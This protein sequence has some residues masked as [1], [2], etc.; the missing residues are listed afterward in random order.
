MLKTTKVV[1][2][3]SLWK[4]FLLILWLVVGWNFQFKWICLSEAVRLLK[5]GRNQPIR[6]QTYGH[7]TLLI[8]NSYLS[9]CCSFCVC[10]SAE[11]LL[12]CFNGLQK[13][14]N[15]NNQN[16][17]QTVYECSYAIQQ[18]SKYQH[19][20]SSFYH[21]LLSSTFI[22]Y[23]VQVFEST[24]KLFTAKKILQHQHIHVS[25]T[26]KQ[27]PRETGKQIQNIFHSNETIHSQKETNLSKCTL[28][29]FNI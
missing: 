27:K 7:V 24:E 15:K 28:F 21:W 9:F 20:G 12:Q 22:D 26:T 25:E 4:Y 29:K 8:H 19:F 17:K 1:L 14:I 5:K 11:S 6:E 3:Q 16:N 10:V 13:T 2:A 23:K 18:L